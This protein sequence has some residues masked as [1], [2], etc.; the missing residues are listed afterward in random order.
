MF[1][2]VICL[3]IRPRSTATD[4]MR[5]VLWDAIQLKC[6]CQEL[7][8]AVIQSF[9]VPTLQESFRKYHPIIQCWCGCICE[10]IFVLAATLGRHLPPPITMITAKAHACIC[11]AKVLSLTLAGCNSRP[12]PCNY[13]WLR[14]HDCTFIFGASAS[15]LHYSYYNWLNNHYFIYLTYPHKITKLV[16]VS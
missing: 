12:I 9:L 16:T 6:R 5:I 3:L 13:S 2:K 15:T 7:L 11:R 4:T 10:H 1:E 8:M 14:Y